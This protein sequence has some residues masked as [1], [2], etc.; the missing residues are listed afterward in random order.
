M[1]LS[2]GGMYAF[3]CM[4]VFLLSVPVGVILRFVTFNLRFVTF[5]VRFV[6]FNVRFVCMYMFC[7]LQDNE[8]LR[9]ANAA[10]K[11]SLSARVTQTE[12]SQ[13]AVASKV[14]VLG[15]KYS[16]NKPKTLTPQLFKMVLNEYKIFDPAFADLMTKFNSRLN[17]KI[18]LND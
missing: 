16:N 14:K 6:T 5:N 9:F 13:L 18:T 2:L 4:L 1:P 8:H 11:S 17:K 7:R 15:D 3:V 12:G 10:Q